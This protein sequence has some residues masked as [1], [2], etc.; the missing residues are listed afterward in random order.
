MLIQLTI[1]FL[2]IAL[3]AFFAASEIALISLNENKIKLSADKGD[4]K[5]QLL[6]NLLEDPS[7]FLATIQ[8]GITLAGF[9]ASAFASETFAGRLVD[10]LHSI[11]IT[12]SAGVLKP[13]VVVFIT[14]I[15]AYFTLVLGE[16]VPKRMAMQRSEQIARFSV[17]SLTILSYIAAPFVKLLTISTNFFIKVL[18]GDP[19]ADEENVT[20]EEIRIMVDVGEQKGTIQETEKFFI[21]NIFDF[22]DTCVSEIM[23]HR[24]NVVGLSVEL[25]LPEIIN[26]ASAEKY[27][28]YP[29]YKD[30]LDNIVGIVH[31]K[32]ILKCISNNG[33]QDFN[34]LEIIRKPYF[35][36]ESKK[37]DV[38]LQ[39]LQ[40]SRVHMAVVVDEYGGT[41]G[42]IT[43]EDL[44]E[45][46]VGNIEDEY[47]NDDKE[48]EK[49]DDN[50]YIFKGIISLDTVEEILEIKLPTE[51]YDT[52]GGFIMGQLGRIPSKGDKPVVEL[53]GIIFKVEEVEAQRIAKVKSCKI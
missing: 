33:G 34:L 52:L 50:T 25:S 44:L 36:P 18:G 9:L 24:T 53:D 2:L 51:E 8:I 37:A 28:R 48:F 40:K 14:L 43:I 46:I 7:R 30:S 3:N 42:I 13:I 10:I 5:A 26:I 16:L 4:K 29:V 11:G 22:D 32:D 49:I 17:R 39:E 23:T 12:V 31:V 38:L 41:A 47:D 35:V 21:N 20:E 19:D 15:L 1:L 6:A 45:E 27:T